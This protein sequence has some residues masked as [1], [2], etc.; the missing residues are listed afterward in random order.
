[1][2]RKDFIKSIGLLSGAFLIPKK[3]SIKEKNPLF[4]G[5]RSAGFHT[6]HG[7]MFGYVHDGKDYTEEVVVEFKRKPLQTREDGDKGMERK[8]TAYSRLKLKQKDWPYDFKDIPPEKVK[9]VQKRLSY[10]LSNLGRNFEK[11]ARRKK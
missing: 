5:L 8:L 7:M 3:L 1:M 4:P 6:K 11:Q 10:W 9:F 2:K